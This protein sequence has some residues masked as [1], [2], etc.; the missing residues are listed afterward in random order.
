ML[1]KAKTVSSDFSFPYPYTLA[2]KPIFLFITHS[3]TILKIKN[4]YFNHFYFYFYRY[5][6]NAQDSRKER[7]PKRYNM[8]KP[9]P[10]T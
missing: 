5:T 9:Q 1:E 7:S 2:Y 3:F 10:H 6:E 4:V 8:A